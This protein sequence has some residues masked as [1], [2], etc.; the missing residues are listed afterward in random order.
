MVAPKINPYAQVNWNN[1]K[2]IHSTT[3]THVYNQSHFDSI[4]DRGIQHFAISHYGR[5]QHPDIPKS[6][7][8]GSAPVYPLE[9][10]YDVPE[11][12][13]GSPNAEHFVLA[14]YPNRWHGHLNTLGSFI[15]T[16]GHRLE[17]K[18]AN[19]SD[20]ELIDE[21][22]SQL[23]FSDGGGIVENHP[24]GNPFNRI[25]QRLDYA[26]E[27]IGI[28]MYNHR[29][30]R[31]TEEDDYTRGLYL[32]LWDEI[33]TTGRRCWGFANPDQ[34]VSWSPAGVYQATKGRNIVLVDDF[35]SEKVLKAYRN[36]S[37]YTSMDGSD[38]AF[39]EISVNKDSI[40]VATE[41]AT[42]IRIITDKEV[43]DVNK[44]E[45]NYV[46]AEETIFVRFEA[47]SNSGDRIFS[48]PILYKTKKELETEPETENKR[49]MKYV[50]IGVV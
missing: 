48:Q 14:D 16:N 35:T 8:K 37:F 17:P 46:V 11:G 43:I 24:N 20:K 1:T 34:H 19:M 30:A 5:Q 18:G 23:Q 28:E 49:L 31:Y 25:V 44:S 45:L 12:I 38:L 50:S 4:I 21:A 36:G 10:W 29:W 39:K 3:H 42:R 33:S 22:I 6:E 7:N 41:G 9:D 13:I 26:E 32:D 40:K 2:Y 15:E 47:F 27:F